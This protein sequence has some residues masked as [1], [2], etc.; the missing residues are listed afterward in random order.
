MIKR[1]V[2]EFGVVSGR[3]EIYHR[4]AVSGF[5]VGALESGYELPLKVIG[6]LSEADLWRPVTVSGVIE[7]D[8]KR[9]GELLFQI[10][11]VIDTDLD[12]DQVRGYLR[13]GL[14]WHVGP[15]IAEAIIAAYREH[16]FEV[17]M[18]APD[19]L[20]EV[21]GLSA[22]ML[23]GLRESLAISLPLAG[24]VGLLHPLGISSG[25]ARQVVRRHGSSGAA[26]IRANPWALSEFAG[27]G[28]AS[29]DAVALRLGK[30]P[31][32]PERVAAALR[33]IVR[34]A[35]DREGHTVVGR[36]AALSGTMKLIRQPRA[37]V[38][39]MLAAMEAR[40]ELVAID[41]PDGV[42]TPELAAAEQRL[43]TGLS[44]L[45]NAPS[46]PGLEASDSE[47][48]ALELDSGIVFD[49]AQR[50]A[51]AGALARGLTVLTGGPGVG[52]TT[53]V[54]AICQLAETRGL[55]VALT[56][57]TGK[58][59]KRLS[60]ATDRE[61]T[62]IHRYL[63]FV[64]GSGFSGPDD[65]ADLV[66]VD[67]VSMLDVV[68][69]DQLA[70]WLAPDSRLILVGDADQLPSIGAGNVLGDLTALPEVPVFH[71]SVIH[72]TDIESGIPILAQQINQGR[73]ELTYDG[74][75]TR[76]VPRGGIRSDG[77]SPIAEWIRQHF[78]RY[79]DRVEEFQVLAP[80]KG[81][82]AG[83]DA[84]NAAIAEV[85]RDPRSGRRLVR[86]TYDL[87]AGDRI[88]WTVNDYELG[89]FNGEIGVLREV[90]ANGGA[91][92][93]FD[94]QPYQVPPDKLLSF[95]LAY[96]LTVHKAQGSEFPIVIVAMDLGAGA[97][98]ARRLLYTAVSR[99]RDTVAIVGQS[100]AVA[101]AIARHDE[102]PRRT[103][104][105]RRL[106]RLLAPRPALAGPAEQDPDALF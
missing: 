45:I 96:A 5:V 67:E 69:A 55:S 8:R 2:G 61:A 49:P 12:P 18:H 103:T 15:A 33:H 79:R 88:I 36:E 105:G 70:S 13:S 27:V 1:V 9:Q 52:K 74:H 68:L 32:S 75:T 7:Q 62:T 51:V 59:A 86:D 28:F 56:S 10:K 26:V 81:G 35:A 43:A 64:P 91:L 48:A 93:E 46:R 4:D 50:D 102:H 17:L 11:G 92:V 3:I 106:R 21:R 85:V 44:L 97:M 19:K 78:A 90:R 39:D 65:P 29:A 71:L 99:A 23:P 38:T 66:V 94:G 82:P 30:A 47:L 34:A 53:I 83:V 57:F 73:T 25:V 41:D 31:N 77:T 20:L 16:T 40:R 101:A 72:R 42:A 95:S 6:R 37:A 22:S 89:L 98:L 58:A 100:A 24:V 76:F 60:E 54:R 14:V 80:I 87:Q 63:H 104:L 84:L